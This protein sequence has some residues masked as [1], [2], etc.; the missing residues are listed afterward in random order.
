MLL[1]ELVPDRTVVTVGV[2]FQV[3]TDV[4]VLPTDAIVLLVASYNPMNNK[5]LRDFLRYAWPLVRSELPSARLVVVGDVERSAFVVPDGVEIRGRVDN[6]ARAYQEARVVINPAV[7]GTGL[8]IKT[9]EALA[10]LRPVVAFPAGVE[11]LGS[12]AMPLLRVATSWLEFAGHVSALLTV[13]LGVGDLEAVR[14]GF[15][16]EFHVD[17]VYEPLARVLDTHRRSSSASRS[18]RGLPLA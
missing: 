18:D 4:P 3:P 5:G 2:D 6:L 14:Q 9:V 7:G 8:K 12:V 1:E 16:Q 11:G 17:N 13:P 15:V 10:H